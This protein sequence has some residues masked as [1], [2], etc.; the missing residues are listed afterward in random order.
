MKYMRLYNSGK[1]NFIRFITPYINKIPKKGTVLDI[2]CGTGDIARFIASKFSNTIIGIDPHNETIKAAQENN[3]FTNLV[4]ILSRPYKF[5]LKN[6]SV[7]F[8]YS[9]EVVEHVADD[10]RFVREI[11]RVLKKVG[12][13][14]LTTPNRN[15]VPLKGANPDHKRHYTP[16]ELK[17]LLVQNGFLIVDVAY[18]WSKLSRFI[19]SILTRLNQ[20]ISKTTD[21][22]PCVTVTKKEDKTSLSQI[23]IFIYNLIIDPLI[24]LLMAIDFLL[25]KNKEGYDM[26]IIAKKNK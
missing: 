16:L 23:L 3:P 1:K 25:S 10:K 17:Q 2:G 24:D 19:D 9:H 6:Q 8:C 12:Y 4:Y 11:H 20:S 14:V 13:C 22:Q 15:I 21:L 18:R 5:P 7:E 26:M